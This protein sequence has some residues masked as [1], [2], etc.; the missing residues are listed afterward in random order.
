MSNGKFL[1]G[2]SVFD[3]DVVLSNQIFANLLLFV[4]SGLFS[5]VRGDFSFLVGTLLFQAVSEGFVFVSG[6][7]DFAGVVF[8][9]ELGDLDFEDFFTGLNGVVEG[10]AFDVEGFE[11]FFGQGLAFG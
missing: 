2:Q 7:G 4:E 10:L 11:S 3:A 5:F 9:L 6:E 8:S 1:D